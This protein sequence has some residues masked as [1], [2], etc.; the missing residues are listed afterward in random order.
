MLHISNDCM[1]IQNWKM[2]LVIK[3]VFKT[4]GLL[5]NE[6]QDTQIFLS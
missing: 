1:G 5:C 3:S 6:K 4:L 2:K